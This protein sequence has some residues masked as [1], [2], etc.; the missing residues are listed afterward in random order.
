MLRLNGVSSSG[1]FGSVMEGLLM[2]EESVL[3]VAVK[4][5]KSEKSGQSKVKNDNCAPQKHRGRS[6]VLIT[7]NLSTVFV[8]SCHMYPH[9]DG[10]LPSRSRLH[11]RV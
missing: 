2:Q 7:V 11:E 8:S 3:K 9:R 4:T 6:V 1:E 10:G 5:M